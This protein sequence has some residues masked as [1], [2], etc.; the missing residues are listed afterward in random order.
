MTTMTDTLTPLLINELPGRTAPY[1]IEAGEGE[2]YEINGMLHTI[3]ARP[4]DT[5]GLFSAQYVEGGRGAET[6]FASHTDEHQTLIVFD[7]LV[8]FQLGQVGRLLAPGDTVAV[9]AGTPFSYRFL[10]NHTRILIWSAGGT[11]IGLVP[12][13]GL[14]VDTHVQPVRTRRHLSRDELRSMGAPFGVDYPEQARG[15]VS[16]R[17]HTGRPHSAH[18]YFLSSGEGERLEARNQ[19]NIFI[20]RAENSGSGLFTL[21]TAGGKAPFVPLHVHEHHA[22]NFICLD[23]RIRLHVNGTD[24]LLTKGDF[25]HAPAGTAHSFAFES[26]RTRLIGILPESFETFFEIMNEPTANATY[27]EDGD[28]PS[29]LEKFARAQAEIDLVVVGPPPHGGDDN[30]AGAAA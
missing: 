21:L 30:A 24:V 23:G 22:E 14:R 10:S 8:E 19:M 28:Y 9:A 29:P 5:E 18:S 1:Y 11:S 15:D 12:A 13:A 2:R 20:T 27:A 4:E 6:P 16:V 7:G 3:V 26:H 17:H 25:L